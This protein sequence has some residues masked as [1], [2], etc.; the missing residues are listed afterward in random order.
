MLERVEAALEKI[1][2]F[3]IAD[4]GNV[5]VLEITDDLIV[6]LELEGACGTCP[7]SP[8]TMKAGVEE[9]LKR[10]IPELKGVVAVNVA[11]AQ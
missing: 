5:K 3:L 7:M 1:R 10:D 2:P 9:A 4:G 11:E 8:M 6:K